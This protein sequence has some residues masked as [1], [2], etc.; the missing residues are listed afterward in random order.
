MNWIFVRI[1]LDMDELDMD[2]TSRHSNSHT[3]YARFYVKYS[4]IDVSL[5]YW[6]NL[7]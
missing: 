2:P 1:D 6:H 5:E 7:I 3:M 4:N